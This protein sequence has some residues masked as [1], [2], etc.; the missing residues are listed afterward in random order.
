MHILHHFRRACSADFFLTLLCFTSFSTS[1]LCRLLSQSHS[2][3]CALSL[4][5]SLF[6]SLSL[7]LSL[8]LHSL[9][10]S[11]RH[12]RS[13]AVKSRNSLPSSEMRWGVPHKLCVNTSTVPA[14]YLLHCLQGACVLRGMY[15]HALVFAHTL[16]SNI[17]QS[18]CKWTELWA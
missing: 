1:M 11:C 10:N 4:F 3:F 16:T 13:G 18:S 15:M 14:T 17:N 2:I 5:L 12:R 7:S 6:I 9:S 8:S